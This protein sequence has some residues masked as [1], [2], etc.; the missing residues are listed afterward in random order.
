ME[1][2]IVTDIFLDK[3]RMGFGKFLKIFFEDVFLVIDKLSGG[4]DLLRGWV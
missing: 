4:R 1:I 2:G 3:I